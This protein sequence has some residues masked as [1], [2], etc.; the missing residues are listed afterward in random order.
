MK[1]IAGT[2]VLV[3]GGGSGIGEAVARLFAARGARVTI[4]G[5]REDKVR[6]VADD[7][8]EACAVVAGDVTVPADRQRMLAAAIEHGGGLDTLVN[9]AG[10]MYRGRIDELDEQQMLDLYHANVVGPVQL[11]GLAMPALRER[12]GSVVVFGS[13]HTQR[14]FPGAS[15]Y[16]A[17][18]GAL[19]ALT[20]VLAAE[21][22]PQGVRIN[23]IRPGGVY[24]EINERAGLG[25]PEEAQER[26][27][28]LAAAH[29]I[30]RIGTTEEVAEA[31]AY[32]AEAEWA[33]GSIL[34]IDGGLSLGVTND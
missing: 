3:T 11:T 29:A 21:L 19:E 9:A 16:A 15:P 5:R 8:G 20:G 31:V 4:S 30:G 25:T 12:G 17:T 2:S 6:K 24:T 34:T 26:L 1:Q 27:K 13:V 33:T 32:L 7:I 10:N 14:A 18:K 23:C 22:G 28:G